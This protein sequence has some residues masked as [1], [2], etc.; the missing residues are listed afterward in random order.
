M[1]ANLFS[2]LM[3]FIEA[4]WFINQTKKAG[5][6]FYLR[7]LTVIRSSLLG[8]IFVV[9]A[10]QIFVFS[11]IGIVLT[12]LYLSPIDMETKVWIL[13]GLCS[14]TF[15]LVT[16]L[17]MVIFSEKNWLKYSGAQDIIS[18]FK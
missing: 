16:I 15:V 9:F 17:L 6:L 3:K 8:L 4:K 13:L 7:A 10:F 12:G 1:I 5:L 2:L 14:F 18:N 11:C